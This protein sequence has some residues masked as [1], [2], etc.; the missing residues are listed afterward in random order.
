MPGLS[1]NERASFEKE[2][3][4]VPRFRLSS[5][6]VC[7]LQNTLDRLITDNP[8]VRPEQLISAHVQTPDDSAN[9]EGVRGSR[10]FL[11]LAHD[12]DLLDLVESVIGRDIILWGCAVFCK[13]ASDGMEVPMHQD[14]HY[15]PIRPLAT[16]TVWVAIE[17]SDRENGCLRVVPRSH[18]QK[19]LY[20]HRTETGHVAL[21][22]RIDPK[23]YPCTDAVDIE[24]KAGQLS[25]HDVYMI[26]GSNPNLSTR[27][28]TGVA[29]RYMPASS[30]W[31]RGKISPDASD[32]V[33]NY[34]SRPLWLVRGRDISERND[35]TRGHFEERTS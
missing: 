13:P 11:D 3:Y 6:R 18:K 27:R 23:A 12:S 5:E 34:A 15:W 17:D 26:H 8:H 14:G 35:F 4:V 16:C 20:P 31:D 32:L 10:V 22:E 19:K 25:L 7:L 24:L 2:G 1:A 33:V 29:L 30:Y 9:A 28:R 21:S